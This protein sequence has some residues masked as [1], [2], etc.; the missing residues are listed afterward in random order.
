MKNSVSR[1]KLVSSIEYDFVLYGITSSSKD[2]RIAWTLN[3]ALGIQLKRWSETHVNANF[4][5]F[6]MVSIYEDI[7][8][9]VEVKLLSNKMLSEQGERIW[10]M[11]EIKQY[12]YLLMWKDQ[13]DF[14]KPKSV[15]TKLKGT[16]FV[17]FAVILTVESL[18]S[19]HNLIY[20]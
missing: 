5:A 11:P 12:D 20:F 16:P 7:K 13:T 10:L 2:Y 6:P 18:K 8:N 17:E 19:K 3:H 1:T 9:L 15:L 4:P 14:Y